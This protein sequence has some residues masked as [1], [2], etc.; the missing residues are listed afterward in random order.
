M[1]C[2]AWFSQPGSEVKK[3]K[4]TKKTGSSRLTS[5]TNSWL[6]RHSLSSLVWQYTVVCVCVCV[7]IRSLNGFMSQ[8]NTVQNSQ[9]YNKVTYYL[10]NCHI[11]LF[12]V[13]V[14]FITAIPTFNLF[15]SY[16]TV[17]KLEWYAVVDLNGASV[18]FCSSIIPQKQCLPSLWLLCNS[19][20]FNGPACLTLIVELF[21]RRRPGYRP[22]TFN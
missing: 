2:G 9:I 8:L 17:M 13:H 21:R 20:S 15:S 14:V 4:K 18:T 22:S 12:S 6:H 19:G 5:N 7:S 16:Y 10:A 11:L 1:H 3:W